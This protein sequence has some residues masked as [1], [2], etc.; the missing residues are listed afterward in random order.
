MTH[1][2]FRGMGVIGAA[3]VLL[4][5][6]CSSGT[7]GS[8]SA[9]AA[10]SA[11]SAASASAAPSG[12]SEVVVAMLQPLTGAAAVVGKNGEQGAQLAVKQINDA[13]GVNGTKIKLE[14]EDTAGDTATGTN[15][16]AKLIADHP[17]ALVGPNYS[18]VALA[19]VDKVT[20]DKV[21]MLAGALSPDLT[22]SASPY[23]F[24]IRSSDA[25]GAQNLVDYATGQLGLKSFALI[26]ESSDYGQGGI[27]SVKADLQAKGITPLTEQTFNT[28]VNDLTSQVLAIKNSGAE[29][30]IYWGSQDP[31]ALFAKQAKQLGYTG[32]ILGSNAY[33]DS[34]VLG[35]AGDAANGIY[36]VVNFIPVGDDPALKSFVS[37][38]NSAYG[39]DP[40]SYAAS[41]YDA[42][43]LLAAAMK[44][45]GPTADGIATALKTISYPGL[46]GTFHYHDNGEMAGGQEICQVQNGAPVV[47]YHAQ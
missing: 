36:A 6:A 21:P 12:P 39:A 3:S 35:L 8:P 27:G 40:D 17:V 23:V 46:T 30:T 5:A 18:S 2:S 1:R 47:I 28:G 20:S 10:A 37:A 7:G 22:K 41:F 38:Y 33:T 29:A 44:A 31:A 43:N 32:T 11:S 13:G 9:S 26:S 16:Y 15:A 42:I 14:V 4:L 24:R 19:L 45:G 34:S 25:V